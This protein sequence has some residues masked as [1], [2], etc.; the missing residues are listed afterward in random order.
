MLLITA[1]QAAMLPL[2]VEPLSQH[3]L[4]LISGLQVESC[5]YLVLRRFRQSAVAPMRTASGRQRG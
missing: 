3:N 2:P 4:V 5:I 1:T